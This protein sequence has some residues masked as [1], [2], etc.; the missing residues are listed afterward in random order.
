MAGH[1]SMATMMG[2]LLFSMAYAIDLP[3]PP[4]KADENSVAKPEDAFPDTALDPTVLHTLAALSNEFKDRE[5]GAAKDT[6]TLNLS[7]AFGNAHRPDWSAQV[8]LPVVRY[9]ASNHPGSQSSS[10]LGDIEARI[11]HV[12]RSE[13]LFRW[14]IGGEVEFDTGGG[15]PAGDGV[16]R[17]SPIIAFALQPSH[18]FKFQTFVQFNQSLVTETSVPE[19]QEI[20]V[21]PAIN[22]ALPANS[23]VYMEYEE[24]WNLKAAGDFSSTA[25]FEVGH[26]FGARGEWTL[27]ARCEIPLTKSSDD[28]TVTV[29]CTYVFK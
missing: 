1:T 10:G 23:Y 13:G 24:E 7:Y 26:A 18:N 22:Y 14:A 15:K 8:D 5:F 16:F 21:K 19:E 9:L 12:M 28:Y 11:G 2:C 27:S 3:V 17:L 29:G 20:H 25:K 6:V 4:K